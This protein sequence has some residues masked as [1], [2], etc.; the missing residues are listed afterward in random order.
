MDFIVEQ[1]EQ[2]IE[3]TKPNTLQELSDIIEVPIWTLKRYNK[4]NKFEKN[5]ISL[6][7]NTPKGTLKYFFRNKSS[8][9]QIIIK[10]KKNL[11]GE[12]DDNFIS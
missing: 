10:S 7:M 5:V 4:G 12:Y 11:M 6:L 1:H 3:N 8:H 2:L 9:T